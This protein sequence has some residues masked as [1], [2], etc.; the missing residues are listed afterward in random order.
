MNQRLKITQ[1]DKITIAEFTDRQI[2]KFDEAATTEI[3]AELFVLVEGQARITLLLDFSNVDYLNSSMLGI[4]IRLKK[5][6][7]EFDGRLKLCSIKSKL[8]DM[9]LFTEVYKL[10]DICDD[11]NS[12]L[13]QFRTASNHSRP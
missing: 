5:R 4:L 10:F 7:K 2:S 1:S 3:A 8:Y 9:F 12:A 11:Q 6:I 13:N